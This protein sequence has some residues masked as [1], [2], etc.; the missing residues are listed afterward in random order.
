MQLCPEWFWNVDV[1]ALFSHLLQYLSLN[2]IKSFNC[3]ATRY[4][5]PHIWWPFHIHITDY[6]AITSHHLVT[7]K[8]VFPIFNHDLTSLYSFITGSN[9]H[10]SECNSELGRNPDTSRLSA[11][12]GSSDVTRETGH[13]PDYSHSDLGLTPDTYGT[14]GTYWGSPHLAS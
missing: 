10:W 7:T 13:Y 6:K 11:R 1:C 5:E 2:S 12:S 8:R 3:V 9:L 14:Q 4:H